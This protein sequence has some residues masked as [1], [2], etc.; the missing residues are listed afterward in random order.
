MLMGLWLPESKGL[1]LLGVGGVVDFSGSFASGY[2]LGNGRVFGVA[3]EPHL[4]AQK[5]GI[6]LEQLLN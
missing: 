2:F 4:V 5:M 6:T 3:A 1:R